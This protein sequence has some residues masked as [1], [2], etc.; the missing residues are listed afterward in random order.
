VTAG[1]A[2]LEE[3]AERIGLLKRLKKSGLW[4]ILVEFTMKNG[5]FG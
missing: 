5:I 1:D 2:R 4:L 3:E